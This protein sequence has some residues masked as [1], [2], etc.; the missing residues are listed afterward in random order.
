MNWTP[1]YGDFMALAFLLSVLF[2]VRELTSNTKIKGVLRAALRRADGYGMTA[3]DT[4]R[5]DRNQAAELLGERVIPRL[6][7]KFNGKPDRVHPMMRSAHCR[8]NLRKGA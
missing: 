6:G 3:R 5:I 7:E 4:V 2:Y 8:R 1:S